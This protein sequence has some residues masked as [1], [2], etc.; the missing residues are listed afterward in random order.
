MRSNKALLQSILSNLPEQAGVYKYFDDNKEIIYI[1]KAK[2]LKKRVN[3]Y[4]TKT[5]EDEKT[6]VLVSKICHIEYT[7]V[8]TEFDALL[9]EN[10]LIKKFQPKYNINL[11][12]GKSY[13]LIKITKERFPRIFAMRNKDD[14]SEYYGPYSSVKAMYVVLDLIN[15]LYPTRNCSYP[16]TEK[17]VELKKY[18]L[19]LEYQI[20]NCKG[21]CQGLISEPEYNKQMDQ[22]RNILKGKIQ[23][24]KKDLKQQIDDYVEKMEFEKAHLVK[25]NLM[26]LDHFQAKS[27][28]VSHNIN[29]VH[30]FNITSTN[31]TSYVNFLKVVDGMIIQTQNTEI[32]KKLNETDEEILN[33]FIAETIVESETEIEEIILPF[34]I[35]LSINDGFKTKITVPQIGDKKNLLDL[36]LKNVLFMK[37]EKE[38]AAEK[39]DPQIRID[40]LLT[41]M[42]EDLKLKTLPKHIECFDNSNIQGTFPVSACVVFKDAKPSKKDYRHFNVKTVE[43]PNDFDTMKE[44]IYRRYSRLMEENQPL[45]DLIVV[46]GGKGQLS[47]AVEVLKQLNIYDKVPI[48]GIAKKLEEL[49]Y[50]N[51]PIPL[52]LNKKSET[53]KVIQ[54]M[55]DEAHRFGITHHRNRRSKNFTKSNIENIE[56]IGEKT[57]DLLLSHFKSV[58][59]IK[60]ASKE[61]LLNVVNHKIAEK[62]LNY[63]KH[64]DGQ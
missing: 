61:D 58:K 45:P 56:G 21:P 18:K 31:N 2:N 60:E 63:F 57:A 15:K 30:V 22:I 28:I 27:T 54:Q 8:D 42:K 3:S 13:P 51:D 6:R 40:R 50:P 59:K 46:D 47:S 16:L 64:D 9:L 55:R 39:L 38:L 36:S 14:D 34:P 48:I 11:K 53:L 1:G 20:G 29:N 33:Y 52:Y 62:I 4:F 49:F 19:C 26:L 10:S 23:V 5:H 17:N 12:D 24:V 44:V 41:V 43:G 37:R 32:K 35:E 7:V 25:E